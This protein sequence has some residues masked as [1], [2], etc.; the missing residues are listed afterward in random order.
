[1]VFTDNVLITSNFKII[2]IVLLYDENMYWEFWW[3]EKN[4]QISNMALKNKY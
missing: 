2:T 3:P 4:V 1:M